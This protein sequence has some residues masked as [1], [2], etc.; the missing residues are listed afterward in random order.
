MLELS[1]CHSLHLNCTQM[2]TH[3]LPVTIQNYFRMTRISIY[4]AY[5]PY[6]FLNRI[7][8]AITLHM[9]HNLIPKSPEPFY[10]CIYE[11]VNKRAAIWIIIHQRFVDM[12]VQIFFFKAIHFQPFHNHNRITVFTDYNIN[13]SCVLP[14]FRFTLPSLIL[15]LINHTKLISYTIIDII[16]FYILIQFISLYR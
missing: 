6:F 7:R 12:N 2:D 3:S 4:N 9:I 14:A 1:P 16:F 10:C 13:L 5:F 15:Y 11:D 8:K